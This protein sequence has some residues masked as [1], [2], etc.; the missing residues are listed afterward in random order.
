[1]ERVLETRGEH[2]VQYVRGAF[3]LVGRAFG[4]RLF[5]GLAF[6]FGGGLGLFGD[7]GLVRLA[8]GGQP[9]A[10]LGLVLGELGLEGREETDTGSDL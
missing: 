3:G 1:M 7:H 6:R 4:R 8:F 10:L 5:V 9:L 2:C